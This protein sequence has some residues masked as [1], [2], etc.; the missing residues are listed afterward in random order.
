MYLSV[1]VFVCLSELSCLSS[2]T[3]DVKFWHGGLS[4]GCM[5]KVKI[6]CQEASF[7]VTVTLI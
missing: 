4:Q 2:Y 1:Q 6:K 5:S 7:G 3:F